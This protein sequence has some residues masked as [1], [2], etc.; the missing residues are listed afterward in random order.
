MHVVACPLLSRDVAAC[1]HQ[2][3]FISDSV[4]DL[5]CD[6]LLRVVYVRSGVGDCGRAS[7]G[8]VVSSGR[9]FDRHGPLYYDY[10]KKL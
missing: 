3:M 7:A 10:M 6:V 5:T 8:V 2:V 1:G 4:S 9:A